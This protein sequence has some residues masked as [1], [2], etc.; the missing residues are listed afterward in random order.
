MKKM[1][2][3]II[4]LFIIF[5]GMVIYRN[6]EKSEEIKI[7]EIQNIESF[8][9]KIYGWKEVTK[10]ALPEF[11]NIN[12]ADE[13]WTWGIIRKNLED[14]ELTYE[15]IQSKIKEIYGD[16][17]NKE[18]P[19][20][21]TSFIKNEGEKY[22][23]CEIA[24][25]AIK[26][27]FFLNKI[28]RTKNGYTAEIAEYLVDYTNSDNGKISIKNLNEEIIAEISSEETESNIVQIIKNNIDKF[29]KKKITLENNN[30][31]LIV[32]KVEKEK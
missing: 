28:E 27:S 11:D 7:G 3:T 32:K 16:E 26:D 10:E 13:T 9:Q 25:D 12:N 8:V 22:T 4:V 18:Y 17:L 23:T 2:I 19:K 29:S 5:I 24:L 6:I 15:E 31:K 30:E 20:E 14:Y 1:V 21:G